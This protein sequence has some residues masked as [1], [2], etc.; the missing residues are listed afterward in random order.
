MEIDINN[1]NKNEKLL[2]NKKLNFYDY[3]K[4]F[5]KNIF[6]N[7]IENI[8][9]FQ[10]FFLFLNYIKLNDIY[11]FNDLINYFNP[12]DI[13]NIKEFKFFKKIELETND[14]EKCNYLFRKILK[15]K[16]KY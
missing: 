12:D 4:I 15:I 3:Y 14:N 2:F 7:Y 11:F 9:E 10:L 1:D 16:N 8:N 13:K 6:K 5:A